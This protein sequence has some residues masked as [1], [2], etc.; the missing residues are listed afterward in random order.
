MDFMTDLP[1][2][3]D[4]KNN[5][6]NSIL[7]IIDCLIKIMHYKPVKVT[8]NAS[9]LIEIIINMVL[10]HHGLLNFII[11]ECKAIIMSKFWFLFCSYFNIKRWLFT[12]FYP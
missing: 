2:S 3:A 4:W 6:Y 11:I 8:I 10:R 7:N 1:L 12:A 9:G 5:S